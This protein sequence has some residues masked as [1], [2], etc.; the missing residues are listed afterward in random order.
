MADGDA[1][2][3]GLAEALVRDADAAMY[4][5]KERG[6]ARVELFDARLRERAVRRLS[7]ESALHRALERDELVLHYQ[8]QIDLDSGANRVL[9]G[10][11]ALA[12]PRARAAG[13]R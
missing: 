2:D 9:G 4:R 3:E 7:I 8:P 6:K 11:R 1:H 5:A 13:A 12:A 10:A